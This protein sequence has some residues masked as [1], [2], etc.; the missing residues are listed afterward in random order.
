M[1][2]MVY[3]GLTRRCD[4]AERP[5]LSLRSALHECL[6]LTGE[7]GGMA[8]KLLGSVNHLFSAP[9]LHQLVMDQLGLVR[10]I[11]GRDIEDGHQSGCTFVPGVHDYLGVVAVQH[12]EAKGLVERHF[13]YR[14]GQFRMVVTIHNHFH[15]LAAYAASTV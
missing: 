12:P 10:L 3:E 15:K 11:D 5:N 4:I 13:L 14:A 9:P 1:Q 2:L 6:G 7:L 8:L